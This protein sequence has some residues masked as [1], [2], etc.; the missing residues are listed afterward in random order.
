[1]QSFCLLQR[2][3]LYAAEDVGPENLILGDDVLKST[4]NH[5]AL[6]RGVNKN[7]SFFETS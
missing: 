4:I 1:M 7:L 3:S 6:T 2:T 5:E